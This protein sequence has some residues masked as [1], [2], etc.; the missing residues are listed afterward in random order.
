MLGLEILYRAAW[1]P[2]KFWSSTLVLAVPYLGLI[3]FYHTILGQIRPDSLAYISNLVVVLVM[4]TGVAASVAIAWARLLLSDMRMGLWASLRGQPRLTYGAILLAMAAV[5]MLVLPQVL[6]GLRQL[7]LL[8]TT[9]STQAGPV[10]RF[11]IGLVVIIARDQ[12]SFFFLLLF[13]L[14]GC[15]LPGLAIGRPAPLRAMALFAVRNLYPITMASFSAS[16][17]MFLLGTLRL[18]LI[19]PGPNPFPGLGYMAFDL[20]LQ[21]YAIFLALSL[22][23]E[24]FRLYQRQTPQ[25]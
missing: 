18:G 2:F 5:M 10:S 19:T 23:A 1:A 3:W 17:G 7:P 21:T 4:A 9:D 13:T 25:V 6:L 11:L 20:T 14:F 8:V 15:G 24:A 16:A 22:Q 12:E